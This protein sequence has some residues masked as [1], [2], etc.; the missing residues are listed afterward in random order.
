MPG[1]RD[2][3]ATDG[4]RSPRDGG[5]WTFASVV[6]T[7]RDREP[8]SPTGT[9]PGRSASRLFRQDLRAPRARQKHQRFA[10]YTTVVKP[11]GAGKRRF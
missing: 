7:D 9:L 10:V 2:R 8:K 5:E 6:R 1:H 11:E 3:G 4:R